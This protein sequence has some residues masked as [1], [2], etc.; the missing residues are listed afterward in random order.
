LITLKSDHEIEKMRRAGGIVARILNGVK[1]LIKP[2]VTTSEL[3]RYAESACKQMGV[4]PA[5]KGYKGFPASF[6]ISINDEVVHGIPSQKRT[7]KEGDIVGIDFGVIDDGWYGDAART[8]PVGRI[9][10][11]AQKLLDVTR[12]SLNCGI[13]QCIPG[14]RLMDIGYA[15]QNYVESIGFSVVREFVGHGIGRALH[16]EPQIPN[17]GVQGKGVTLKKGMVFAIEPMIN[18][19]K[20]DVRVLEDGWTAVTVDGRLSAHFEHMVAITDNGPDILTNSEWIK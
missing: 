10:P 1:D 14:N 17:W 13:A 11:E 20:A 5:F 16:E 6:C 8:Y 15:I 19:G 7:L 4:V 2:G 9:S 18:A 3:D 12:E